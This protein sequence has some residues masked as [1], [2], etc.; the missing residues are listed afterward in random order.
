MMIAYIIAPFESSEYL[1]RCVNSIKRQ[2]CSDYELIIAENSFHK[3]KE[4]SEYLANLDN[5]KL[6]SDRPKGNVEKIREAVSLVS[7]ASE[8]IKLIAVD[9]VL[10]PA[11]TAEAQREGEIIFVACAEK[12]G[13]NYKISDSSI[14]PDNSKLSIYSMFLKKS[15]FEQLEDKVF[16]EKCAFEI[17]LEEQLLYGADIAS[18]DEVCFYTAGKAVLQD[19][20]P[21]GVSIMYRNNILK[22]VKTTLAANSVAKFDKYLS[23]F[24]TFLFNKKCELSQK[25]DLFSFIKEMG[26]AAKDNPPAKQLYELYLEGDTEF[27]RHFDAEGYLL[28]VERRNAFSKTS[29]YQSTLPKPP[30]PNPL[31]L[32][33]DP[34]AEDI[35]AMRNDIAA[36]AKNM[37]LIFSSASAAGS[38]ATLTD[39]YNQ[40]P[41]MF[42][43][44][45]LGM[46]AILKSIKGWLKYKFSRKKPKENM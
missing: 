43:Q 40:V 28:Y 23:R 1:I 10:S 15:I 19:S 14:T 9:T 39:P 29:F 7:P 4:L 6:I 37:H 11:A 8:L 45:Q 46:K 12:T 25:N 30:E 33:P 42:S 18:I 21:I 27:I 13:N 22:I 24:L 5:L 35:K 44:G 34:M 20:D 41:E 17:W 38:G 31:A 32:K 2:T 3:G 36:I 26:E 16:T